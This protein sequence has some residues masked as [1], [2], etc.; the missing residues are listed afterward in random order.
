MCEL[1]MALARNIPGEMG[2]QLYAIQA[3]RED[4]NES[5]PLP[6]MAKLKSAAAIMLRKRKPM[7]EAGKVMRK[8]R[9]ERIAPRYAS[10]K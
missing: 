9:R 3:N 5:V 4:S 1:K 6:G 8:R 7:I 10:S 2:L